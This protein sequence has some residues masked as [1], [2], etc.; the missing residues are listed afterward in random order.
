M[1]SALMSV[2]DFN[3]VCVDWENG[4]TLPNYVKASAN[5]RLVGKQL[6]MLLKGLEEKVGLSRKNMHLIGFSLGAHVA[7]FAGS[8]MKNISRITGK[9]IVGDKL[10]RQT[11]IV[12][13]SIDMYFYFFKIII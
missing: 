12:F 6:A 9:F 1:R 10:I 4:A 13:L 8:E 3:I 11:N 7:G 2:D 5:A